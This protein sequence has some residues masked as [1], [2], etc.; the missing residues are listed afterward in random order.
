MTWQA[1][2]EEDEEG[3]E[4]VYMQEDDDTDGRE[5]HEMVEHDIKHSEDMIKQLQDYLIVFDGP[6]RRN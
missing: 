4:C 5:L 3:N 1:Y 2:V 6:E